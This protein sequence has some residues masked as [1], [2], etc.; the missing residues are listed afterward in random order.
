[1]NSATKVNMPKYL[2]DALVL[3]ISFK[4][5]DWELNEENIEKHTKIATEMV[6][7]E[8]ESEYEGNWYAAYNGT[9]VARS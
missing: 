5:V 7:K 1:M 4:K 9:F 3:D 8:V 6:E 2:K